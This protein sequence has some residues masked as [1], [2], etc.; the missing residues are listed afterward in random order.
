MVSTSKGIEQQE[1]YI[2]GFAMAPG[3][4]DMVVSV[5]IT[6]TC[7]SGGLDSWSAGSETV[8]VHSTDGGVTWGEL[9][10][11]GAGGFVVALADEGRAIVGKWDAANRPATFVYFPGLE[12]IDLP[13]NG[14][15]PVG[16]LDGEV[17]WLTPP[18]SGLSLG[19]QPLVY[20][21]ENAGIA[22][23]AVAPPNSEPRLAVSWNWPG[24]TAEQAYFLT[25][26]DS[27][28]RSFETYEFGSFAMVEVNLIAELAGNAETL[29]YGQPPAT[30]GAH[31]LNYL[32]ATVDLST[33]TVRPI[34]QPFTDPDF[35][36]GRNHI[37]AVQRGP[38]ARVVNT[39]NT[40]VNIRS[41]PGSA[42]Q[43]VDCAAEGVLLQD[44]LELQFVED[45]TWVR[46]RAPAGVEGWAS[47]QYLEAARRS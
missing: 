10:R 39:D 1:P 38:F 26:I 9:G 20:F 40:C 33:R 28:G 45:A 44:L 46:V 13:S 31:P 16:F 14:S 5:C 8:I 7:G 6:E 47:V 32:P 41:E 37:V 21:G 29:K 4:S 15:W 17:L 36:R 27:R 19:D 3:A 24:T 18:G 30:A 34:R 23:V 43:V 11:L 25:L 42:G 35:P 12:P 2:T 22:S